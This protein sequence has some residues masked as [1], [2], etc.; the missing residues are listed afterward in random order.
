MPGQ[1]IEDIIEVF[2]DFLKEKGIDIPNDEKTESEDPSVIYGT[3]Y[4]YLQ[5]D[6]EC[7]LSAYD[8]CK[9]DSKWGLQW[10]K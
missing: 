1:M 10:V 6:L 8:V 5:D 7:V 2:E 9:R 4:G 3:D